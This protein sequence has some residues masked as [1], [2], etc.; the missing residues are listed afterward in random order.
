MRPELHDEHVRD[1]CRHG[2]GQAMA[3]MVLLGIEERIPFDELSRQYDE[4]QGRVDIAIGGV[5]HPRPYLLGE[6]SPE[7]RLGPGAI[8]FSIS[9]GRAPE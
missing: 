9:G 2:I 5:V 6:N 8:L 1:Y 7:F 4:L 3:G